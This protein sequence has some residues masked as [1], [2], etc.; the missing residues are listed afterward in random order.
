MGIRAGL[1]TELIII[2]SPTSVVNEYGEKVQTYSVKYCTRARVSNNGG[3]RTTENDEIFYSYTK[4]FTVRS[5][6]P[7]DERDIIKYDGKNYRIITIENRTRDN[8]DKLL[9]TEL[10]ND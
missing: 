1:L 9:I 4:T 5:Y 2:K 10:I 3:T 8:N 7:V 6:V